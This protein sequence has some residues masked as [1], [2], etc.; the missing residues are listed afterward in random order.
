MSEL[1]TTKR[2]LD[3]AEQLFAKKGFAGTSL[4]A[5]IKAADV[6]TA[7]VHYHF[8]SKEGLIEAVLERRAGPVNAERL[9]RLD[10]LEAAHPNG[11]LPLEPIIEAFLAPAIRMRF[12]ASRGGA[13]VPRLFGRAMADSDEKLQQIIHGI[14]ESTFDRFARAFARS[15]PGLPVDAVADRMHF[16]IGAMAFVVTMPALHRTA[17][18]DPAQTIARLVDFVAGGMRARADATA[19]SPGGDL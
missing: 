10:A 18:P 14:F 13:I 7:S 15:L 12:G 3:A 2:I 6:N 4:R 9:R 11:P 16:M 5:V 8:G 17:A 19:T 1:T